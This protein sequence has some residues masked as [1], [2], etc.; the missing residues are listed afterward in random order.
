VTTATATATATAM[1]ARSSNDTSNSK[2]KDGE[3]LS[4]LHLYRR[5]E[6]ILKKVEL[7][8]RE[9]VERGVGLSV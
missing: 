3:D 1:T 4:E 8:F 5:L 2:S 6:M 9:I 7:D